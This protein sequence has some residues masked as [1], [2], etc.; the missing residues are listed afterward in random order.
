M[1]KGSLFDEAL[2]LLS[3]HTVKRLEKQIFENENALKEKENEIEMLKLDLE[4]K[5]QE[6]EIALK[7]KDNEV[8]TVKLESEKKQDEIE[9]S[10]TLVSYMMNVMLNSQ[11]MFKAKEEVVVTQA[12]KIEE[13]E[14]QV[15]RDDCRG[16]LCQHGSKCRDGVNTYYCDCPVNWTGEYCGQDVNECA[17]SQPCQNHGT[18]QN[19]EGGYECIC[20]NGFEG[21]NCELN[22][23]EC[24]N[25]PC[26]NG[27]TC[28][29]KVGRYECECPPG[30][31]GLLCHLEDECA[32]NP[33]N[34]GAR[35][36]TDKVSGKAVCSCPSGYT[37]ATCDQDINECRGVGTPCEHGGKC[38][39]TPGSFRCDCQT[40]YTGPRCF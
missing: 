30:K 26:Q 40:G 23:D 34:V 39:N 33:C 3:T 10:W 4:Q 7:E 5:Q 37:G 29:D 9:K 36:D 6:M 12:A 35:C 15:N 14:K 16:H 18:C 31:T 17:T 2:E 19:T 25:S 24:A 20:V 8:E 11:E 13:M 28:H 38:V 1:E 27:G 22:S 21:V 32:R